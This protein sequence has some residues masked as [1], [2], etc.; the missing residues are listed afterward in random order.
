MY[1]YDK[2]LLVVLLTWGG[3]SIERVSN[4]SLT[5]PSVRKSSK[6]EVVY[7]DKSIKL[8]FYSTFDMKAVVANQNM[9]LWATSFALVGCIFISLHKIIKPFSKK[10]ANTQN[11]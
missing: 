9:K 2:M 10:S 11:G 1:V 8:T 3:L 7:L 6:I 5:V 4:L